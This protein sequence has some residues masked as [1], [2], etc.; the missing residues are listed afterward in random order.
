MRGVGRWTASVLAALAVHAAAIGVA[1]GWGRVR[2]VLEAEP[3]QA[4]ML[5]VA[6][7]AMAPLAMPNNAPPA[8]E[9]SP[10]IPSAE[11]PPPV[12]RIPAP[13]EVMLPQAELPPP[14]DLKPPARPAERPRPQQPPAPKV[15]APPPAPTP[16]PKVAAAQ[17]GVSREQFQMA[18]LTWQRQMLGHLERHKRYPADAPLRPGQVATTYVLIVMERS[19]RVIAVQTERSSGIAAFDRE[20]I[21]RVWRA[22]P[23]PPLPP[24]IPGDTVEPIVPMEFSRR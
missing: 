9:I 18:L 17:P 16:A 14:L 21:E 12:V 2:P 19:G 5:E 15:A 22:Q 3:P 10:L 20:G 1:L 6:A 8:S 4:V 23:L 11:E 24:E 7:S 13:H